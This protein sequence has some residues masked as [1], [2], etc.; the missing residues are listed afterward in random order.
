MRLV[1]LDRHPKRY[2]RKRFYLEIHVLINL[3]TGKPY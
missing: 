2:I 1:D 3:R